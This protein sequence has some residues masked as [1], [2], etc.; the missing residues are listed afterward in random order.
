[1]FPVRAFGGSVR[2]FRAEWNTN[3]GK[4]VHSLRQARSRQSIV[5]AM[6]GA[7]PRNE[8]AF[9]LVVGLSCK[10]EFGARQGNPAIR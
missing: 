6:V 9:V 7:C 8:R 1:M 5:M 10:T 2:Q 3:T 4:T